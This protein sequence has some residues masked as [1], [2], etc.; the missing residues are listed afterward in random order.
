[1]T[2]VQRDSVWRVQLREDL[3]QPGEG[4]VQI[5]D[6]ICRGHRQVWG[7]NVYDAPRMSD[8]VRPARTVEWS[9]VNT[10][11][12]ILAGDSNAHS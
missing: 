3:A 12:T 2:G 5:L 7:V 6:I 8:Q 4:D 10:Q 1:M 9:R 11:G